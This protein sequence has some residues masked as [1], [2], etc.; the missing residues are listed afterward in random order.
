MP[1][2]EQLV[3]ELPALQPLAPEHREKLAGC[4]RDCVFQTDELIMREGEHA[5]AFYVVRHGT[6]ALETEVPGRGAVVVHT[7]HDGELL[8]WS[9]LVPP[10]RVAF[11][12][13][14]L[15]ETD[16]IAIDGACLRTKCEADPAL[17]YDVMKLISTVFAERLQDTRLRLLDVYGKVGNV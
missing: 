10:Y 9:W 8:G 5:D 17:G 12:A 14:S 2:I 15:G 11:D 13:R 16:A 1:T 3:H 7:V 6:V 4:A